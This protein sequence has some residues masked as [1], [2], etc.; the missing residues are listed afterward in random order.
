MIGGPSCHN[1]L[2]HGVDQIAKVDKGGEG[3]S[4][5]HSLTVTRANG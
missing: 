5:S 1:T 3:R 2:Y 4:L